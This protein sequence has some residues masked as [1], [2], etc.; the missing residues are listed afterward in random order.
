MVKA[1]DIFFLT[2]PQKSSIL[3]LNFFSLEVTP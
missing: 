1:A 3:D 2:A